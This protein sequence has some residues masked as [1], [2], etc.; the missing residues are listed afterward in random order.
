MWEEH[1]SATLELTASLQET[2]AHHLP[3]ES[4]TSFLAR[5]KMAEKLAVELQ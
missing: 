2:S 5:V 3:A 1:T 4:L